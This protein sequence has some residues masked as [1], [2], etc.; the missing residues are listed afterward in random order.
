M[1]KYSCSGEV[2]RI[3]RPA[4]PANLA[5]ITIDLLQQWRVDLAAIITSIDAQAV[6]HKQDAGETGR[7]DDY[8]AWRKRA[9]YAKAGIICDLGRVKLELQRRAQGGNDPRKRLAARLSRFARAMA[10]WADAP[11]EVRDAACDLVMAEED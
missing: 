1:R 11:Q 9:G 8:D 2:F 6:A 3:A 7:W 4:V 10:G 5:A